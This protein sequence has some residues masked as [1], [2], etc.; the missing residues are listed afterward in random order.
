VRTHVLDGAWYINYKNMYGTPMLRTPA[1]KVSFCLTR[2]KNP[3]D[4]IMAGGGGVVYNVCIKDCG[5]HNQNIN[6]IFACLI[7]WLD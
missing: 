5:L 7:G 6:M 2:R 4:N 1:M 3:D